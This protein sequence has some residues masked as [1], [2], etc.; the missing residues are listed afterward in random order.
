MQQALEQANCVTPAVVVRPQLEQIQ[1]PSKD[2][3]STLKRKER[4]ASED[5]RRLLMMLTDPA[6]LTSR[7]RDDVSDDDDD[8]GLSRA[9]HAKASPYS[10]QGVP[11]AGIAR[12][13]SSS[14]S[15]SQTNTPVE[16][17]SRNFANLEFEPIESDIDDTPD[18]FMSL[19]PRRNAMP[20]QSPVGRES[21]TTPT[22]SDANVFLPLAKPRG[23]SSRYSSSRGSLS[24]VTS[25]PT[26]STHTSP[27]LLSMD[28]PRH[29]RSRPSLE[30]PCRRPCFPT[31][32]KS[33][34]SS[35]S[36]RPSLD[37]VFDSMRSTA[38]ASSDLRPSDLSDAMDTFDEN[39]IA[40]YTPFSYASLLEGSILVQH[41]FFGKYS[42]G[43]QLGHGSFSTVS[44]CFPRHDPTTKLAVKVIDKLAVHEPRFL[45][46][47]IEIM[48]SLHHP[49]IV[50]LLELFETPDQL[51]LVMEFCEKELFQFIDE[52]G[53]LPE[54]QAKVLLRKLIQTTAYL[55]KNAIVHRDIKP[56]NILIVHDDVCHVKLSDF[57]IARR[58]QGPSRTA[59]VVPDHAVFA[60]TDD[61]SSFRPRERFARAHT[62]CG[63]RDYVAP[64]VMGGKGYGTQADM[65]SIGVV[66]YVVLSGYA[67]MFGPAEGSTDV[68]VQFSEDVWNTTSL[69][70]KQLIMGL[71]VRNPDKRM[72]ATEAMLHPWLR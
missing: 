17:L 24:T 28:L 64:E 59:T 23:S 9:K 49:G 7:M 36:N 39:A 31:P 26:M 37:G 45:S 5:R 12:P 2:H 70:A 67:P 35:A 13:S 66:L 57:G 25:S 63:T 47:E 18:I 30:S 22:T 40:M 14:A 62:K 44:E 56:E 4:T 51:Y 54:A 21:P 53:P 34:P 43:K 20:S 50:K 3:R 27:S 16:M 55:H 11:I 61:D 68:V 60:S 32:T 41:D 46:R 65:W 29:S 8:E 72:T 33:R 42:L 58:L 19:H 1:T 6:E 71:L 52:H 69:G 10:Q 15:S 48:S 38:R